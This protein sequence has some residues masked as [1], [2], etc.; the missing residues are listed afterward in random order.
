MGEE[1]LG[2]SSRSPLIDNSTP[3]PIHYNSDTF[4]SSSI[5]RNH[6]EMQSNAFRTLFAI[7]A[8]LAVAIPAFAAPLPQ[9]TPPPPPICQFTCTRDGETGSDA[10][11]LAR[12][13]Q[14]TGAPLM[15]REPLA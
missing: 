10:E 9:T 11:L 2:K 15:V 8:L 14:I 3:R 6:P 13:P 1:Q 12:E 4:L 5:T 7:F